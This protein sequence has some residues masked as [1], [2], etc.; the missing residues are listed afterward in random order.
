M[1]SA[2]G[3]DILTDGLVLSIDP[4]SKRCNASSGGT[5]LTNLAL[6]GTSCV[7]TCSPT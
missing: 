1:A 5:L 4:A 6:S 3:P 2:I 7:N